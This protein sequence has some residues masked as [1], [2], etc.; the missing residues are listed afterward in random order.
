[1]AKAN[2]ANSNA[3]N[4]LST[5]L[6]IFSGALSLAALLNI[7]PWN[8]IFTDGSAHEKLSFLDW[9]RI[10]LALGSPILIIAFYRITVALQSRRMD[11]IL[12]ISRPVTPEEFSPDYSYTSRGHACGFS[13]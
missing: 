5:W 8:I 10:G 2:G 12:K 9:A 4:S 7:I 11:V 13:K 1:M 6:L 3:F